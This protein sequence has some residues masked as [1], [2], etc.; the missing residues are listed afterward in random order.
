MGLG[1]SFWHGV[2]ARGDTAQIEVG[3]NCVIQDLVHMGSTSNREAGDK[4]TI[5]DN[6]YVGPN[7]VL[8][9]C[10][11]ESFAY[12][13]MGSHVGKGSTIES[14]AVVAAGAQIPEGV[15]VPSGQVWAGAPARYLRDLTQEEKHLISEHHLEMQQLSQIYAESTEKN[16]RELLEE[17]DAL[18]KYKFADPG[19]KAQ[20]KAAEMGVPVTSED[21]DYIEHRVYHDY[22]G[23]VDYDVRDPAHSE[24]SFDRS[25]LPYEQDMT[26]Y[27][28]VFR[29]YQENYARF[30]NLK[31]R[32]ETEQPFV[33]QGESPFTRRMPKDMS[34]WEKRYDDVMPKYNGT[35][36][37]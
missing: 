11:L 10:T 24:G 8:D 2:I 33:E 23:T 18:I 5:G 22:V 15:S 32:F 34:P 3:K 9:S 20:D 30:D 14:F 36:C 21:M 4:V 1:S 31:Q 6:V 37:Q 19:Q 28:E 29:Q 35:L 17:R 7:A 27:P 25:W 13:G 12:V 16:F 26:Q